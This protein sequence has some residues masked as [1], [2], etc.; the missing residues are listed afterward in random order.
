MKT[1][2]L[3][4][5]WYRYWGHF[6]DEGDNTCINCGYPAYKKWDK[7]YNGYLGFCTRCDAQWRES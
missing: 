1:F 6:H 2:D 3:T 4:W 7:K 5:I